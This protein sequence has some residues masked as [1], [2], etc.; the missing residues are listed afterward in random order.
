MSLLFLTKKDKKCRQLAAFS[1]LFLRKGNLFLDGLKNS[2]Y[3]LE[4]DFYSHT[5]ELVRRN[6]RL[7]LGQEVGEDTNAV[8]EA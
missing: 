7:V 5:P 6:P 8:K 1:C 2:S 3:R 4:F